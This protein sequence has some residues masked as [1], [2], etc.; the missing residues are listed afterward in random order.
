MKTHANIS[1]RSL[2]SAAGSASG[3][4][5]VELVVAV[6][7]VALLTVGIGQIFSSVGRLVGAG[8]A[9]AE[10]DQFA[11]SLEGQLRADFEAMSRLTKDQTFLVIRNRR[12]GD[13]DLNGSVNGVERPAYL[14]SAD[15]EYDRR[16]AIVPYTPGSR[17]ITVRLDDM[18][19]IASADGESA[20]AQRIPPGMVSPGEADH[21]RI[22]YGH[23]LRPPIDRRFNPLDPPARANGDGNVPPRLY[24]ADGDFG[25]AAGEP[26]FYYPSG[27]PAIFSAAQGRNEFAGDWLL[28]RQPMLLGGGLSAGYAQGAPTGAQPSEWMFSPFIRGLECVERSFTGFGSG[29]PMNDWGNT[30]PAPPSG[31]GPFARVLYHGRADV[32]AQQLPEV[33]R[34]LEGV[35][36]PLG[37]LIEEDGSAFEGGLLDDLPGGSQ[38]NPSM[39]FPSP[40]IDA[41]LWQRDRT[42]APGIVRDANHRNV[43]S[44]IAGCMARFQ[45]EDD[46]PLMERR[47]VLVPGGTGVSVDAP[48][49][50]FQQLMD[51][52]AVVASRVSN[53][54]IAWSDGKT[55]PYET[56]Y[57]R[58]NDDDPTD[59]DRD[60]DFGLQ[61]NINRGDV[62][63]Y[64]M[65]FTRYRNPGG[66]SNDLPTAD[67]GDLI[68][69]SSE[70]VTHN[71]EVC[72]GRRAIDLATTGV[73]NRYD[74]RATGAATNDPTG[75]SEY[76]AVFPF[77]ATNDQGGYE[78]FGF[79]KPTRI[80]VR[81][82][83]HDT[84]FRLPGGRQYEFEFPI[85]VR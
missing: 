11:R 15:K 47:D 57:D 58:L 82:T 45:A 13:L 80:R 12:I 20:S 3:F 73:P 81:M 27:A 46:P 6:A 69:V 31:N 79:T 77:R 40:V 35:D 34:W 29:S 83:V 76:L 84:Q 32:C 14:N 39:G 71:P 42:G 78:R 10:T 54:E 5:L 44:A 22:Y 7:A 25:A 63:W 51:M 24:F 38:W 21:V 68:G 61:D 37:P 33:R 18:A 8:N 52:H 65:D 50:R 28:L 4:T 70:I 48:R 72:P 30:S 19:F 41:P 62:I 67:S 85:D 64:D 56:S 75:Q 2:S 53:F 43:M 26:N 36:S 9:L 23:G 1:A 49:P 66:S 55:W 60:G 59:S 74:P 17:A 16:E